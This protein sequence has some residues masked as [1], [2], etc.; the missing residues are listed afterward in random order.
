M[1]GSV[2]GNG[3]GNSNGIVTYI[4]P[5][6]EIAD[7]HAPCTH[8]KYLPATNRKQSIEL[9]IHLHSAR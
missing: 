2:S 1:D 3:K 6:S 7:S 5:S 8:S 9:K 4:L